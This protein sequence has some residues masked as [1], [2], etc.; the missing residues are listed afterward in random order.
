[1]SLCCRSFERNILRMRSNIVAK[2]ENKKFF[3][4]S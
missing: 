4:L 3:K 2:V 1:M